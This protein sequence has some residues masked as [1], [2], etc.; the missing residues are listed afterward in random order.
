MFRCERIILM[1]QKTRR[2]RFGAAMHIDSVPITR[3]RTGRADFEPYSGVAFGFEL[4]FDSSSSSSHAATAR[5]L[6]NL[7]KRESDFETSHGG[8]PNAYQATSSSLAGRE[9]KGKAW[10]S[11]QQ[12]I[13]VNREAPRWE[14]NRHECSST[15]VPS[16]RD[17]WLATTRW[18]NADTF[19]D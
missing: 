3:S 16:G 7:T 11:S 1:L 9:E 13:Q 2:L 18:D 6:L 15:K 14:N 8:I 12:V 19:H 17:C 10:A 5:H 4:R